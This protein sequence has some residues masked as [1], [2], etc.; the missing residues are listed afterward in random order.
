MNENM[1]RLLAMLSEEEKTQIL[2]VNDT[3]LEPADLTPEE[4][5]DAVLPH[6]EP[7]VS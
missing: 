4:A 6:T 3:A 5:K 7:A 1:K 2:T